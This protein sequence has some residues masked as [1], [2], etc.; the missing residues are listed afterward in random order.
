MG[1]NCLD[2]TMLN[3]IAQLKKLKHLS[4]IAKGTACLNFNDEGMK[5]LTSCKALESLSL[6]RA[7]SITEKGIGE[8][9]SLA[10]L[11]N[12]NIESCYVK[13]SINEILKEFPS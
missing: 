12:I 4:I 9:K 7:T 2:Y 1:I 10:H 6:T 11:K 13:E 8:L 5:T 3:S